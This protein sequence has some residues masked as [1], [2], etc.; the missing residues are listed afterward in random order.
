MIGC[1]DLREALLLGRTLD[2]TLAAHLAGC[3]ECRAVERE[4]GALAAALDHEVA[5]PPRH[6]TA[7]VL[8]AAQPL[9]ARHAQRELWRR[10][11][12]A[13]AAAL[14]PLPIVLVAN[15]LFV[16]TVY[17][18]MESVLPVGVS[19][20][21]IGNY[22]ALLALLLAAIYGAIPL[23]AARQVGFAHE[24]RHG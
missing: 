10:S 13:V 11:A 14:I 18:W 19:L 7:H 20:F 5:E 15:L 2:A 12:R 17:V 24:V 22:A 21:L 6:A 4:L 3:D 1:D 16:R 9:L 8:H 23:L